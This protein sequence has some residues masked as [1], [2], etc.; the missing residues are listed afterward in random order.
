MHGGHL[1]LRGPND[2]VGR[3]A[4]GDAILLLRAVMNKAVGNG[5]LAKL[6]TDFLAG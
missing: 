4:G 5:N 2:V 6:T 3:Q 1:R